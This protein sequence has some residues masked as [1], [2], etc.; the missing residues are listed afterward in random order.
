MSAVLVLSCLIG[1]ER[2]T[3]KNVSLDTTREDIIKLLQAKHA[4]IKNE[5]CL[6][7]GGRIIK[8]NQTLQASHI[9]DGETVEITYSPF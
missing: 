3:E 6:V 8:E 9:K 1:T 4:S 7:Y 2:Y 5:S